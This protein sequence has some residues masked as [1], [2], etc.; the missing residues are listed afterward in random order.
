[1]NQNEPGVYNVFNHQV[2]LRDQW[3]GRHLVVGIILV[4]FLFSSRPT[5]K[6]A[7]SNHKP[8]LWCWRRGG[9]GVHFTTLFQYRVLKLSTAA[10][11]FWKILKIYE[12]LRLTG[13]FERD[14]ICHGHHLSHFQSA[15]E[16]YSDERTQSHVRFP[17]VEDGACDLCDLFRGSSKTM[18]KLWR[19]RWSWD[20]LRELFLSCSSCL[21][22]A[23]RN[24]FLQP[25][26]A[27]MVT[28]LRPGGRRCHVANTAEKTFKTFTE[29][30]YILWTTVWHGK[31]FSLH[32][33]QTSSRWRLCFFYW[34]QVMTRTPMASHGFRMSDW[35]DWS[36]RSLDTLCDYS[37]CASPFWPG[38]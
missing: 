19:S 23:W 1:M 38:R 35:F 3:T 34:R 5:S 6:L 32:F 21:L 27:K 14:R 31:L 15:Q 10:R 16:W 8:G 11:V 20:L 7:R 26:L 17:T 24:G 28:A 25:M 22:E 2:E 9:C 37:S 4:P 29:I 36:D 13:S 30:T 33:D 18:T 12:R